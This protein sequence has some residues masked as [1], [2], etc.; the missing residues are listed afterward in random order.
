MNNNFYKKILENCKNGIIVLNNKKEVVYTNKKIYEK[1][2]TSTKMLLG[3]YLN[4]TYCLNNKE[5]CQS[6]LTCKK[7]K[8]NKLIDKV[9]YTGEEQILL[10]FDF[11]LNEISMKINLKVY[12]LE[13]LIVIE[14]ENLTKDQ[15]K[16]QCLTRILDH[17][18]DLLFFKDSNLKYKYLNESFA[19]LFGKRKEE[20]Y[21]KTDETLLPEDL[22]HQCLKGD[23]YTLEKGSYVGI[24]TFNNKYYQVLKESVDGGVLGIAKDIT[25]VLEQ[26]RL[27][28]IDPLTELYNRRKFLNTIDYIYENEK[29]SYYLILIDL[30]NLRDL[31]NS[32]GHVKGDEYLKKLGEILNNYSE[33]IFFRIGGDEFVGL[34]N[35][36]KK[37]TEEILKK[38]YFDLENSNL[39]PKLSISAGIQKLDIKKTY[40]ENYTEVDVLL[41]QAKLKGK[42]CYILK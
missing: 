2:G 20:I 18:H 22:Y 38:I 4:C 19:K 24:E 11:N 14:V 8:I 15:E 26:R 31:N 30:D 6:T 39:D 41:Y 5:L 27:A 9:L 40:L 3:N 10:N 25:E 42:N 29:N 7:C 28:E 33:G 1:Y 37:D 13:N 36:S 17:S 21:E 35:R 16:M 34:I 23:L 32:Y 12:L